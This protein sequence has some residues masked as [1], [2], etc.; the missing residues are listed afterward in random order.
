M[1]KVASDHQS[2]AVEKVLNAAQ[3]VAEKA[4]EVIETPPTEFHRVY[5][6]YKNGDIQ[7]FKQNYPLTTVI[8]IVVFGLLGF[9]NVLSIFSP[10]TMISGAVLLS[11]AVYQGLSIGR[12][13]SQFFESVKRSFYEV[14]DY[15][16]YEKNVSK[17]EIASLV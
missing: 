4:K 2:P 12:D 6:D 13:K 3:E 7:N 15:F 5:Q 17:N 9:M 11:L 8:S 1:T 10:T 16:L 14:K